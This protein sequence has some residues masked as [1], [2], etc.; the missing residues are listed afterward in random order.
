M[1][2]SAFNFVRVMNLRTDSHILREPRSHSVVD[3]R[4]DRKICLEWF[5]S[6]VR[7]WLA[8]TCRLP[9]STWTYWLTRSGLAPFF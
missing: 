7:D 2:L 6:T 9:N 4:T 8:L 3:G 1:R 5:S